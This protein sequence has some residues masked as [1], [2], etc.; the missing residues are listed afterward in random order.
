MTQ[1]Y[2]R[3]SKFIPPGQKNLHFDTEQKRKWVEKPS[4][5]LQYRKDVEK[6]LNIRFPL[7]VRDT[8]QQAMAKEFTIKDM[9]A[10]LAKKPELQEKLLPSFAVGCRRPTPGTGYLEALCE[11]NCEV[12]WGELESF[13]E[14]GIRSVDGTERDFDV[15]IAATGF[16]MSFIPRWPII[17]NEGKNLQDEWKK[18]PVCYMSAIAKDM[19]NYF[20]YL[21]PGSPVGHGSIITSI[22]RI[23]LYLT[24][25]ITKLQDENYTSFCIKSDKADSF[26]KQM[27]TWL[28]K[29]VWGDNCQSSFKNGTKDGALHAL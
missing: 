18:N 13:T 15:I 4:E 9:K 23:T 12:V 29:T 14:T 25:I 24:D 27:L 3:G 8:A 28:D 10:R 6:E 17:G 21:G 16:D 22:E 1:N 19:P 20:I 2:G 5:Y 26:Q 7:F 11:D